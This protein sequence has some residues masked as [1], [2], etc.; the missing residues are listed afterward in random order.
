LY[1]CEGTRLHRGAFLKYN[2]ETETP[3]IKESYDRGKD[4]FHLNNLRGRTP[5]GRSEDEGQVA[6][7]HGVTEE[8]VTRP[9]G[10]R[11]D[12]N[13]KNRA[14]RD[15]E[16]RRSVAHRG[17]GGSGLFMGAVVVRATTR[18]MLAGPKS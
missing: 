7:I 1:P 5:G 13:R 12:R 15:D 4:P 6:G 14:F 8:Q 10:S 3:K 11:R 17:S 2:S 18:E 16:N 9:P